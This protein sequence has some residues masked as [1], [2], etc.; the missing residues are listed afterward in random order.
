MRARE[1]VHLIGIGGTGMA[2]VAGLL[3]EDGCRVTGS[4]VALYPPTSTILARL[5]LVVHEGFD[6]AHLRPAPDLVVIGN[7]IRRGNPEAEEV[8]DRRLPYTSMPRLLGERFLAG[9]HSIVVAGTHGK[10]TTAA[11]LAWVLQQAGRDPGFL[12][13][14]LP[15]NLET[16]Y[17]LGRGEAFVIEGDEYD[18]AFFD[19]GPKFMHYRPDTAIVGTVEF[20]HADIYRDLEQVKLAFA[21]FTNLVPRRG[22]LLRHEDCAVTREVTSEALC[23]LEGYGLASG[24]WWAASIEES[25]TLTRFRVLRGGAPFAEASL[26]VPGEHNVLNALAVVGAAVEQGLGPAEIARGLGT[27]QGVSRRLERRGEADGILVL[28]DFAHHPTAIASTLRAARRRYPG[29][30]IWAVLEPRSWSLRRN[31]FQERLAESFDEADEVVIA[32]VYRGEQIPEAERLDPQ[33]LA[34]QIS[35]RDRPARHLPGVPEIVEHLRQAAR[36]GDVVVAMS[37]GSFGGLHERLLAALED[38]RLGAAR[39]RGGP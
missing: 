17:R 7:A 11:L 1:H 31:V 35:A 16:P 33:A 25:S 39:A 6:P 8:L 18:T 23:R 30:R 9:R 37:N 26:A 12:I 28:D 27:F 29:R 21:R 13:G 15:R 2:A 14:G 36:S 3:H 32:A 19:K 34:R 20:D 22:L 38:R 4:D 24:T 5:G 10:T